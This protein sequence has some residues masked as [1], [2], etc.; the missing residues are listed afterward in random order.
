[1]SR[2]NEILVDSVVRLADAILSVRWS[3]AHWL[4][5]KSSG[6]PVARNFAERAL[7]RTP[8]MRKQVLTELK[9]LPPRDVVLL[10]TAL[11]PHRC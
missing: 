4:M 7:F 6:E 11:L 9:G 8:Y 5:K 2:G 10:M 1:M 3:L